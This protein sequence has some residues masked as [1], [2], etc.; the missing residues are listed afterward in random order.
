MALFLSL[1]LPPLFKL[2]LQ[3]FL[4]RLLPPL[5]T[6]F[7][8]AYPPQFLLRSRTL[9]LQ[10]PCPPRMCPILP[11]LLPPYPSY[12]CSQHIICQNSCQHACRRACHLTSCAPCLHSRHH[13]FHGPLAVPANVPAPISCIIS[14]Q[15]S[16]TVR[17]GVQ[18]SRLLCTNSVCGADR[19][20]VYRRLD[21]C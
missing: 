6:P 16:Y 17:A 4:H 2:Y 8:P 10:L 7:H 18:R 13:Y 3:R 9:L 15:E 11:S 14:S 5:R 19:R 1:F 20:R 12:I 21:P